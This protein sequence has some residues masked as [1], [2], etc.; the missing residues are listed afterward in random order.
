MLESSDS[1]ASRVAL[2]NLWLM[3][4]VLHDPRVTVTSASK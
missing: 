3:S 2:A 1:N 4:S